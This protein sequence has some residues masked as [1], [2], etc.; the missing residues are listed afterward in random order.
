MATKTIKLISNSGIQFENINIIIHEDFSKKNK[1]FYLEEFHTEKEIFWFE[2]VLKNRKDDIWIRKSELQTK[3]FID[4]NEKFTNDYEIAE[5]D[6]VPEE[7]I[8]QNP[9]INKILKSVLGKWI[10][11]PFF[12]NNN[13]NKDLFGPTDWVR[14]MLN[15]KENGDYRASFAIDTKVAENENNNISPFVGANINDNIFSIS[16]NTD[17]ILAFLDGRKDCE[18]VLE[19]LQSEL[20]FDTTESSLVHIAA[21]QILIKLL[22]SQDELFN[23][24]LLPQKNNSIPVDMVIDVGNSTTC[25]LLFED[26]GENIFNFNKVKTLEIQ[27]LSIPDLS[28]NDPFSSQLVFSKVKFDGISNND[29]F[30]WPSIVR[31]GKE[32]KRIINNSN[33]ELSLDRNPV[34]YSSS[35]KRYLWDNSPS[36]KNWEFLSEDMKIPQPV[37]LEGVTNHLQ[38]DGTLVNNTNDVMGSSPRYSRKS[39]MTFLFLE[40][41]V[42]AFKQINSIKF[43]TEHGQNEYSRILR[44]IV[45]TCPT[46]MVKQEQINLRQSSLDALEILRRNGYDIDSTNIFPSIK[47]LKRPL[48][49]LNERK[50]WTYDEATCTQLVYIYG[51]ISKKFMNK[52]FQFFD[53]YGKNNNNKELKIASVD[54]GGGT[55]DLMICS[56]NYYSKNEVV[57]ITPIPL[58]WETFTLAG[59]DLLKELIRQIIIEQSN[60][61]GTGIIES[62]LKKNLNT[63]NFRE[64]LNGFFGE[65][66]N[67]IGFKGKIM[68]KNFLNQIAIPIMNSYLNNVNQKDHTFT[69]DD[70]FNQNEPC[71]DLLDYFELHFGFNFKDLVWNIRSETIFKISVSVFNKLISQISKIVKSFD[72]DILILSGRTFKLKSLQKLFETYQP[73]FPNR[74][75]NMNNYWIGKWFPFSDENGYVNDQKTVLSVGSLIAL[76]STK[77]N[78]MGNFRINPEHLRKDIISNANFIGKIENLVINSSSMSEKDENF[79]LNVNELPLRI[80]FKKLISKQYPARNLYTFDFNRDFMLE[81]LGNQSKVDELIFKIRE[82]MPLKIEIDR[83]LE[84]SKEELT[85]IEIIDNEENSLNKNYF[86]FHLN[87]LKNIKNYWLDE[88]EFILKI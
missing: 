37:Y 63:N 50:D 82:S 81:K 22:L 79:T 30:K 85:L 77:Y 28:Y 18:W 73:V 74:I 32:A 43:R 83:D 71:K 84:T 12:K 17:I 78:K 23:I 4:N 72:V 1:I 27:D 61:V 29:K 64:K 65:D 86:R 11:I 57:E 7:N 8:L 6:E 48:A 19:H 58:F 20:N 2:Q 33:I 25:A 34:S 75:I 13:I 60:D 49:D 36:E 15:K 10:P 38:L 5:V 80:G 52:P 31:L 39:L 88:G 21:Y 9:N 26:S 42:N 56:Y 46:S 14:V 66:S 45:I 24:Q 67:N 54:I 68:R 44:N 41:Y 40:I 62:R 55:T 70:L 3:G 69:Y 47:E 76:L 53:A 51:M 16:K 35:P 59:D 87:T